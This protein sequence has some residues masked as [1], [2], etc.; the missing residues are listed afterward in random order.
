MRGGAPWRLRLVDY[1]AGQDVTALKK[2]LPCTCV[3]SGICSCKMAEQPNEETERN[4]ENHDQ[5][6]SNGYTVDESRTFTINGVYMRKV[7]FTVTTYPEI[8]Q[9]VN[10]VIQILEY[11]YEVALKRGMEIRSQ[12]PPPVVQDPTIVSSTPKTSSCEG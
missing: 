5:T 9:Q 2:I 12:V 10:Q 1:W 8:L 3:Y 11:V 6:P 4:S 7:C